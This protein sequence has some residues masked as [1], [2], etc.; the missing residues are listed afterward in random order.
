MSSLSSHD[1][2]HCRYYAGATYMG[3]YE[4]P[5]IVGT[6]QVPNA[7]VRFSDSKNRKR[8]NTEAWVIPYECD[9]KLESLWNNADRYLSSLLDHPGIISWDFSMYR[10]MPFSLQQWN[11]FRGRLL[12]SYF[13]RNGGLCIPNIRPADRRS[14]AYC[15]DGLPTESTVAMGTLGALRTSEDRLV[16]AS[17]VDEAVRRL[18]PKNI[19]VYGKAP[20]DIFASAREAGCHVISFPTHT[21]L[22]FS[23][24]V[25]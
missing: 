9:E 23:K 3:P 14:Y 5:A 16:F 18:R 11:C 1:V 6:D 22:V 4:M 10:N 24:Q 2:F 17:C 25:A 15:F 8:D 7:L 13:E 12:G 19:I 20:K 21:S